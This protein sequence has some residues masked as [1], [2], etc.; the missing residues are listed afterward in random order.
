M[1]SNLKIQCG[2]TTIELVLVLMLVGILS[3]IMVPSMLNIDANDDAH[4]RQQ[5]I[6]VLRTAQKFSIAR[7]VNTYVVVTSNQVKACYDALCAR[8]VQNIDSRVV[9]TDVFTGKYS[10]VPAGP[11]VFS[12]NGDTVASYVITVGTKNIH[13]E[14]GSG[15]VY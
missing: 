11:V 3:A 5:A 8:A 4:A 9:E 6:S 2:F 10:M 15:Y 14:N 1:C 12:G 13:V 7:R